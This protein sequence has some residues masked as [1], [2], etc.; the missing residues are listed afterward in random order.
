MVIPKDRE[1]DRIGR[2]GAAAWARLKRDTNWADWL[3]LG[4]AR[5]AGRG[6]AMKASGK[7]APEGKGYILA[8]KRGT[9]SPS[10]SG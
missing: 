4:E 6:Y 3:K 9:S 5:V 7:N 8:F 1:L 2:L 10:T